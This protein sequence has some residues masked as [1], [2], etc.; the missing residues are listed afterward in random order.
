MGGMTTASLLAQMGGKTSPHPGTPISSLVVSPT[1]SAERDSS[2]MSG[3]TTLD[4]CNPDRC[5]DVSWILVSDFGVQWNPMGHVYEHI[6]L[7][8]C[9][10]DV[11]T[12]MAE[13]EASIG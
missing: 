1:L 9:S 13:F 2:G 7:P 10:F 8:G 6:R 12:G 3:F 4:K 5:L 11:A